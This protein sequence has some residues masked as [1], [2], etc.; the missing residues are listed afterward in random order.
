VCFV[1]D[2]YTSTGTYTGHQ[3]VTA[4]GEVC[5]QW[6]LD[7]PGNFPDANVIEAGNNCRD[8]DNHSILWCYTVTGK[9]WG[10]CNQIQ[11]CD[12]CTD[13]TDLPRCNSKYKLFCYYTHS[14]TIHIL[15][16]YIF[17]YYTYFVTEHIP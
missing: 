15:L 12:L 5:Q 2:C 17:C 3:N 6:S 4:R 9:R 14:V 11:H 13:G 1:A 16:L 8:P 10:S 7:K